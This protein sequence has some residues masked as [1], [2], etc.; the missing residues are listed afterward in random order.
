MAEAVEL[1]EKEVNNNN[2]YKY[3]MKKYIIFIL[4]VIVLLYCITSNNNIEK[5]D[6]IPNVSGKWDSKD[7]K[8]V[9]SISYRLI[10]LEGER[11][12]ASVFKF[13]NDV[14]AVDLSISLELVQI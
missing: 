5:F 6:N 9:T 8:S 7:L 11:V 10:K 3:Y 4:T 14:F 2:M 1:V 13:F 12:F